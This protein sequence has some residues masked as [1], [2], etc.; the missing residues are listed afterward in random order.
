MQSIALQRKNKA[1]SGIVGKREEREAL[2]DDIGLSIGEIEE[3]RRAERE[4]CTERDKRW[5]EVGNQIL[6]KALSSISIKENGAGEKMSMIQGRKTPTLYNSDE[7]ERS[8]I[9]ANFDDKRVQ[10]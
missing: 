8:A 4:K 9:T 10:E 2:L 3:S 7:E 5:T 6:V 1:A